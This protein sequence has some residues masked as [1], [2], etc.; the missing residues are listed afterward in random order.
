[1]SGISIIENITDDQVRLA[2]Y[3]ITNIPLFYRDFMGMDS[4]IAFL[5]EFFDAS[6]SYNEQRGKYRLVLLGI[7]RGLL[8]DYER[9]SYVLKTYYTDTYDERLGQMFNVNHT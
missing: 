6:H 9:F 5:A 3:G 4:A 1:M 2:F 7:D 8:F